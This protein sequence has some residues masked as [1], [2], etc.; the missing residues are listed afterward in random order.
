MA[1]QKGSPHGTD[2]KP[3]PLATALDGLQPPPPRLADVLAGRPELAESVRNAYRRGLGIK[4]LA[5][6]LTDNGIQ[7][8]TTAV[9]SW[10]RAQG[11]K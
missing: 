8:G 9:D 2:L 5:G 6:W 10:L 7:A 11:I 4:T 3:D 1:T